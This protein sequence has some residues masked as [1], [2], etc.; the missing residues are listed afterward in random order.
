MRRGFAFSAFGS[1]SVITPS[2]SSALMPSWSIL[3]EI[4]K[5][6]L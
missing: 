2:F 1:T 4:W 6:R 5:L 3:L